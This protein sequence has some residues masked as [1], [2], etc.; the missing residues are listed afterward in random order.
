MNKHMLTLLCMLI[1][2][3]LIV[4]GLGAYLK[5]EILGPM[6]LYQDK[7]IIELPFLMLADDGLAYS[8]SAYAQMAEEPSEEPTE[9]PSEPNGAVLLS[10]T[11]TV[12]AEPEITET[13][14]PATEPIQEETEPPVT[15]PA[16]TP[17]E[18]EWFDDVLF[19]GNSLTVGLRDYARLGNAEY[20]CNVGMTVFNVFDSWAQDKGFRQMQLKTL[21]QIK[22]YGKIYIHL[23]TNETGYP[24]EG[25][26]QRYQ[27][28]VDMVRQYQPDAVIILQGIM[29][30]GHAK[31]DK[32]YYMTPQ[33]IFE[34]N[35]Q[36]EAMAEGDKMRYIDVN[37]WIADEE[38]FLP[39]DW[40]GDGC[41]PYGKGYGEWAQWIRDNAGTLGIQ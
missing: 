9:A 34:M 30:V 39:D 22:T 6:S 35:D 40:S 36:I 37:E 31:A 15:E 16:Y 21:L 23:G 1:V 32:V 26:I 3:A 27:E 10:Q 33:R 19:I 29:T 2:S 25:F 20:Y 24:L 8:V 4:A 11:Q 12:P 13:E 18:D 17:V 41:H 38:G 28:L 7:S 5:F 14:P